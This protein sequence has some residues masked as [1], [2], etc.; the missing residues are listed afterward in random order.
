MRKYIL[1][2]TLLVAFFQPTF[3]QDI[4]KSARRKVDSLK[5]LLPAA[6]GIQRVDVL[7]SIAHGLL[8]IWED[9]DRLLYDALKYSDEA[10][11]LATK[12]K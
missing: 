2:T 11:N 5:S 1:F 4:D 12:L 6:K 3:S 8:W 10:L 7:N 9:D